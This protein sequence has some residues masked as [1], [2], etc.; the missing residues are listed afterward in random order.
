MREQGRWEGGR[1]LGR[2]T[3]GYLMHQTQR[4]SQGGAAQAESDL[5]SFGP[6]QILT[7][8]TQRCQWN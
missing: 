4:L 5:L 7:S 1:A 2:D 3:K 6:G 8:L